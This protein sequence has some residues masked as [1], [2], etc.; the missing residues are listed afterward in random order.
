MRL[1]MARGSNFGNRCKCELKK[2]YYIVFD[3]IFVHLICWKI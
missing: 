3:S 1:A 2:N